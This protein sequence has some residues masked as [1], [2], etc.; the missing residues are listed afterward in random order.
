MS[1]TLEPAWDSGGEAE[2]SAAQAVAASGP[3]GALRGAGHAPGILTPPQDLGQPHTKN[4]GEV[5]EHG[6]VHVC[7]TP[8]G[9]EDSR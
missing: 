3:P 7:K 5:S 6:W 8:G 4:P 1:Q 2:A 9:G